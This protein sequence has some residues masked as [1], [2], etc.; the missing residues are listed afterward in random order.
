MLVSGDENPVTGDRLEINTQLSNGGLRRIFYGF[1]ECVTPVQNGLHKVVGHEFSAPLNQTTPINLRH[2]IPDK[3]L[4]IISSKT[5]LEFILPNSN[6]VNIT[7][8]RFQHIS[9]GYRVLD[10]LLNARQLSKGF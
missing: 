3:V 5:R 9:G 4:E 8:A 1:V 7:P 2:A 10:Y 6:W